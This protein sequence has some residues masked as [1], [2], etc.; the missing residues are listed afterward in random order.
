MSEKVRERI[1]MCT[2]FVVNALPLF[3]PTFY[4]SVHAL[5]LHFPRL[6][7]TPGASTAM[8]QQEDCSQ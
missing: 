8:T 2:E 3:L 5:G 6:V 1:K 7:H 4:F